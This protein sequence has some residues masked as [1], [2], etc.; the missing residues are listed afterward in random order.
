M[1]GVGEQARLPERQNVR[2][3]GAADHDEAGVERPDPLEPEHLLG[4]R[5]RS[6]RLQAP[7]VEPAL[8]GGRRDSAKAFDLNRWE[9]RHSFE[10]CEPL[11]QRKRR[12][13]LPVQIERLPHCFG[14][15][16]SNLGG[17]PA[18]H[19]GRYHR[20]RGRLVGRMEQHRPEAGVAVLQLA[21]DGVPLPDGLPGV[22][23][24]IER[25]DARDLVTN[26]GDV[27]RAM[28]LTVNARAVL[29]QDRLRRARCG[30]RRRTPAASFRRTRARRACR[31]TRSPPPPRARTARWGRW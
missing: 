7:R 13:A 9:P 18:G 14:D 11:G 8:Q 22:P 27:L 20:P 6:H 23:V 4:G 2:E 19:A 24:V 26:R 30:R 25:E 17:P 28:H 3:P 29:A 1:G 5:L 10:L 15:L 31:Q 16:L 12:H 21:D